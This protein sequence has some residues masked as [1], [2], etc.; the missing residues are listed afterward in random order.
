MVAAP[1]SPAPFAE[2]EP[3]AQPTPEPP[4]ATSAP[5][6]EAAPVS[7]PASEPAPQTLSPAPQTGPAI[8]FQGRSSLVIVDVVVTDLAGN[9][10]DGLGARDFVITEDGVDQTI[11]TFEFRRVAMSPET[12]NAPKSYYILGYYTSNQKQDGQFRRIQVIDK[13]DTTAKLDYRAG[14]YANKQFAP[15]ADAPAG[16][17]VVQPPAT[18]P[19]SAIT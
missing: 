1:P 10:I 5:V 12:A 9:S 18:L 17:G 14:Y 7:Q 4:P 3:A 2:P 8:N 11:S 16:T 6:A 13:T 19:T 15:T